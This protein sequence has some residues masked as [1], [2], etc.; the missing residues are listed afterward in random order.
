MK[1]LQLT[2]TQKDNLLEMCN[3]LF[4]E[5]KWHFWE[6]EQ[7]D[8]PEGMLGYNS[9]ATLGG[10][11]KPSLEIHWFEFCYTYLLERL[12]EEGDFYNNPDYE[13]GLE[14]SGHPIYYLY[15]KFKLLN[16]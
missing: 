3:K 10:P 15:E 6:S 7:E 11:V 1:Q 4:P 8:Y 13:N 9:F 16:V 5:T 14:I 2:Q 12:N